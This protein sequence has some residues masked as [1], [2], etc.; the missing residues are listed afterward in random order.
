MRVR[1]IALCSAVG[2]AVALLLLSCMT[3]IAQLYD[4]GDFESKQHAFCRYCRLPA[5]NHDVCLHHST[6]RI[7]ADTGPAMLAQEPACARATVGEVRRLAATFADE[8]TRL[9]SAEEW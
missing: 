3:S 8:L 2:P 6:R 4:S 1:P 5:P 7:A 9:V